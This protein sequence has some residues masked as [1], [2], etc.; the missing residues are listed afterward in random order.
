MKTNLFIPAIILFLTFQNATFAGVMSGGIHDLEG[1]NTVH[2]GPIENFECTI[3]GKY[4]CKTWPKYLLKFEYKNIC[5]DPGTD[6]CSIGCEGL[7]AIGEDKRPY[8][9]TDGGFRQGMKKYSVDYY[10]CPQ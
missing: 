4:D 7:I 2:A 5:F 1:K 6:V 3:P 8:F 10:K 9:Y